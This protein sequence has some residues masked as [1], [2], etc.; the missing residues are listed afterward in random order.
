MWRGY[1][2]LLNIRHPG[3]STQGLLMVG[4]N[5]ALSIRPWRVPAPRIK[6]GTKL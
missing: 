5:R 1:K 4:I 3:A 6:R 2:K